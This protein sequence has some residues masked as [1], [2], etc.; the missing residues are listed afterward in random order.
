MQEFFSCDDDSP[1]ATAFTTPHFWDAL[2][3][4]RFRP[5]SLERRRGR[6]GEGGITSTREPAAL[7]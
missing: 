2:M 6:H 3:L 1:P 5:S 7:A 4:R